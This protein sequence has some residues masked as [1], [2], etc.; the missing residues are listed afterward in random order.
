MHVKPHQKNH[1]PPFKNFRA[2]EKQP[3][4]GS[5]KHIASLQL[6]VLWS[7]EKKA[8]ESGGAVHVINRCAG[9]DN[10]SRPSPSFTVVREV[11]VERIGKVFGGHSVY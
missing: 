7:E 5:I 1:V 10:T 8:S 4:H 3:R 6:T 2:L 11:A 9:I